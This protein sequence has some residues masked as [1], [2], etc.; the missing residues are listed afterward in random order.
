M[1]CHM[2]LSSATI[3][4]SC[5]NNMVRNRKELNA[6][7]KEAVVSLYYSGIRQ[8]EI[9]RR[10]G[11]PRTTI[12]SV[13]DR[14]RKRG[15]VGNIQRKV[16]PAKLSRRDSRTIWRTVKIN[17]KWSLSDITALF[18][19]HRD[20]SVSKRTIQRQLYSEGY[21]RRVVRKRIRIREVN[22]KNRI[23]WC[24]GNRYKTQHGQL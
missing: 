4:C 6:D 19:Q 15:N 13:I 24:W 11:I 2:T 12:S 16:A 9:S 8:A 7:F 3:S 23:Y 21:H 18:N 1:K 17:K 10:L 5:V 14:F 20:S 22:R